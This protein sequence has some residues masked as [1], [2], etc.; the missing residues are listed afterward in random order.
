MQAKRIESSRGYVD[1]D[2]TFV[3][4]AQVDDTLRRARRFNLRVL[5]RLQLGTR[6][7]LQGLLYTSPRTRRAA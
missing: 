1:R 5:L 7:E 2:G 6:G 4:F 3:T